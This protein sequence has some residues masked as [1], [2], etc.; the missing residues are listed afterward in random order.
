MYSCI[1]ISLLRAHV[2]NRKTQRTTTIVCFS[3]GVV[4][5][6]SVTLMHCSIGGFHLAVV[7]LTSPD[8][9]SLHDAYRERFPIHCAVTLID[10][11]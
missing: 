7:S 3:T 5:C 9:R 6:R 2:Y 1:H 11:L 8:F 4:R 10:R